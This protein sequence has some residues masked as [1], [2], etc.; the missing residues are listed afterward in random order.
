[1]LAEVFSSVGR[2]NQSIFISEVLYTEVIT[3][4]K[5]YFGEIQKIFYKHESMKGIEGKQ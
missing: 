3:Q 4:V 2:D 1:M 5:V